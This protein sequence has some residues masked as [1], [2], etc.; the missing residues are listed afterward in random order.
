MARIVTELVRINGKKLSVATSAFGRMW[1]RMMAPSG[2]PSACAART[3]SSARPR[4]NSARTTPVRPTQLN[5]SRNPSSVQNEGTIM[6]ARM[7]NRKS[8]GIPDHISI[9]R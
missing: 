7:I 9:N 3:Y 1:R 4:R 6:L 2:T 5:A 8:S